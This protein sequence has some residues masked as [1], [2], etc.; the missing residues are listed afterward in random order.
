MARK[1]ILDCDPGID[2]AVALCLALADPRLDVVAVTATAGTVSGEQATR[3]AQALIE[4]LDPPRHPRLGAAPTAEPSSTLE[5]RLLHGDDGLGNAG[6]SVSPLQHVH[7][8]DKLI[9]DEVRAAPEQITIV[10][11]GPLT[12]VARAFQRDPQVAHQVGRIIIVGGSVQVGGNATAAAEQ[13]IYWDP[14]SA[15]RVFRSPCTKTLIPLDVTRHLV[16]TLGAIGELPA[17]ETRAGS[18]LR[19]LLGFYF[20]AHHQRLGRESIQMHDVAGVLAALQP[21]LWHTSDMAGDV[22][23]RGELTTGATIFDRRHPP[24]QRPNMEV[25]QEVDVAAA[26]DSLLRGLQLASRLG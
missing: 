5:H 20:R 23:T 19:R 13:H 6:F 16:L 2:D 10:C 21:E 24:E 1:V 15:R 17:E 12:N 11:L 8:A 18:L 4:W 3:N 9:C 22:E 25:V 26:M 7:A 14:E